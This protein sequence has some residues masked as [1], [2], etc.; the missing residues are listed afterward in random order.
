VSTRVRSDVMSRSLNKLLMK[1][2]REVPFPEE[3]DVS[4]S[5]CALMR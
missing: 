1:N 4:Q 3:S 5:I 2:D